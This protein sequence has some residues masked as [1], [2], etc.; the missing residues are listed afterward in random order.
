MSVDIGSALVLA[1]N[2]FFLSKDVCIQDIIMLQVADLQH[3]Q[4]L[5][6]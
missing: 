4:V 6:T 3:W 5:L 1:S 2:F